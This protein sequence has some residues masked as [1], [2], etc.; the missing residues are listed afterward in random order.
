MQP[1]R[2]CKSGMDGGFTTPFL[3]S[4]PAP[5]K[6]CRFFSQLMGSTSDEPTMNRTIL[7]REMEDLIAKN[8]D[9]FFPRLGLVLQGRQQSFR[10]VGIFDLLFVDRHGMN[11]LMELKAVPARYEVI[12]QV[13]RYRDA[14]EAQGSTNVIM[15]IVSPSVP[16]GLRQFLAHLGIEYTEIH[17]SEFVRAANQFGYSLRASIEEESGVAAPSVPCPAP[18]A[19]A[20][21]RSRSDA[22]H[23]PTDHWGFGK[24]TQVSFVLDALET[25]GRTKEEIRLEY[26]AHFHP[27][28]APSEA[29]RISGF[30]VIFSDC[31]RPIGT[32]HAS[33][34]LL[35]CEDAHGRLSLDA[36]RAAN[37]KAAIAGGI[38]NQIRGCQTQPEKN[39]VL[40]RFGL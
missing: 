39:E 6:D 19:R 16:P 35:I 30:N 12:D 3:L 7:E 24:G 29:R 22:L 36:G 28:L 4:P 26:I 17:E 15:W 38:L 34:S 21:N 37:V 11:I 8:P 14:L 27:N 32:Y 13:A 18:L 31:K 40:R 23:Q 20:G 9:H 5:S 2:R 33:R 10:G 25:G 1:G